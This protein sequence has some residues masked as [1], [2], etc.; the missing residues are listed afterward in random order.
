VE[1]SANMFNIYFNYTGNLKTLCLNGDN[2]TSVQA[3]DSVG[4]PWGWQVCIILIYKFYYG[5]NAKQ[6]GKMIELLKSINFSLHS[7]VCT[8]IIHPICRTVCIVFSYSQLFNKFKIFKHHNRVL[9]TM[10]GS[11]HARSITRMIWNFVFR[12]LAILATMRACTVLIG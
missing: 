12:N 7:Q 1:A 5:I 6:W 9:L 8:E 3:T 4:D 10:K 2:C 11:K